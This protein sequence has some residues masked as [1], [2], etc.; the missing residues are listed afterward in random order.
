MWKVKK[1]VSKGDYTY[2]VVPE[3]PNCTQHGYVLEHRIAMENY[4]GRLLDDDEVVHHLNEDK[5]DNDIANLELCLKGEHAK[6]HSLAQGRKMVVLCCPECGELFKRRLGQ[7]YLQKGTKYTCCSRSCRG[8]FNRYI[9]LYG[10]TEAVERAISENI[11]SLFNTN[12]DNPE[13]TG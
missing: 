1:I 11:V 9:Q 12:D 4:L 3:H 7:T 2:A 13:Q 5:K 10:E 8:K 6:T